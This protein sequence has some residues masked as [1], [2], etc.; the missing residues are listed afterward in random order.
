MG[1]LFIFISL[2][3]TTAGQF[4]QKVAADKVYKNSDMFFFRGL[5]NYRESWYALFCLIAG[6]ASW[7]VVLF[8]MEV[9]K[10]FPFLSLSQVM[11]LLVSRF[12]LHE[13]ISRTRMTGAVLIFSGVLILALP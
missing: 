12:K 5:L 3:F 8:Y 2:F 10:A 7:L 4:Y 9:S 13:K 11:V 1:Y 6:T